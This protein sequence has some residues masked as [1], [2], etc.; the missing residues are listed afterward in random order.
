[1]KT[2][3]GKYARF[4]YDEVEKNIHGAD[5]SK[6]IKNMS[7]WDT[8]HIRWCTST[9]KKQLKFAWQKLEEAWYDD[10]HIFEA[11]EILTMHGA[12]MEYYYPFLID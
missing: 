8:S 5:Y 2:L 11:E 10:I 7:D 1:M 12:K 9:S 6:K 4:E 3:Y